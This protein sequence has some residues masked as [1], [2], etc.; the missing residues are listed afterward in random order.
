MLGLGMCDTDSGSTVRKLVEQKHGSAAACMF[1]LGC[2]AG[3]YQAAAAFD[4][5]PDVF[6]ME[7]YLAATELEFVVKRYGGDFEFDSGAM[8]DNDLYAL[9]YSEGMRELQEQLAKTPLFGPLQF[10]LL[11]LAAIAAVAI[12]LALRRAKRPPQAPVPSLPG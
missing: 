2:Q 1:R 6:P 5:V 10:L 3:S 8:D 12:W 4:D 7:R 9:Y 11:G